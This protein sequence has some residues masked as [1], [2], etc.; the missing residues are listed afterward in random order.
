MS[1]DILQESR[2]LFEDSRLT[3]FTEPASQSDVSFEE[4]YAFKAIMPL[5]PDV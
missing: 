2:G 4:G 5:S 1:P 3:E